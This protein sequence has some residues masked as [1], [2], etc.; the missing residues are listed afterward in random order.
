M[1]REMKRK[2]TAAPLSRELYAGLRCAHQKRQ[3]DL[4]S[5]ERALL[6]T[7]RPGAA[8]LSSRA[9]EALQEVHTLDLHIP[10]PVGGSKLDPHQSLFWA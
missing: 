5:V 6:N 7:V 4:K 8:S 9:V 2:R 10:F 3:A 1:L